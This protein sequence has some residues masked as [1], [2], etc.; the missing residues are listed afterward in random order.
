MIWDINQWPNNQPV[1]FVLGENLS[2]SFRCKII[3]DE[4]VFV[5]KSEQKDFS[6]LIGGGGGGGG[7]LIKE[8]LSKTIQTLKSWDLSK[9]ER[10]STSWGSRLAIAFVTTVGRFLPLGPNFHLLWFLLCSLIRIGSIYFIYFQIF[11]Q[12]NGL[13]AKSGLRYSSQP[14]QP[15]LNHFH[16]HRW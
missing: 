10:G 9:W 16:G 11:S 6:F 15:P 8:E 1:F 12:N 5:L 14:C 4:F 7:S 13:D 2:C 3:R